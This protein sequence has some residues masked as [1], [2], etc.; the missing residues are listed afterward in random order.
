MKLNEIY[1]EDCI[2]LM[3][4][5]EDNKICLTITSPPY[6]LG[7]KHHTGNNSFDAYD[8]YSDDIPEQDYQDNQIQVLNELYRITK[9][10]GSLLYNHKNRIKNG[11]QISPYSWLLRTNW[12][13]KQEIIW[14]NGGQNFDKCRFYPMTERIYWLS[15]GINTDFINN[16]NQHNLL[17]DKC[18]GTDKEHKRSFPIKLA[19][20]FIICF[21]NSKIIFDPYGGS[22]TTAIAAIKEKKDFI[23]SEI[24]KK[25]CDVAK[26]NI[27]NELNIKTL[28]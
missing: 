6:N 18:E 13:I 19:Q 4:R 16:I 10:G 28:F 15:K 20:R 26:N 22:G 21:P 11:V 14:M 2:S 8:K 27:V 12:D 25:Y 3:K 1:N 24:S 23:I 5:I 9:E 7:K 17:K